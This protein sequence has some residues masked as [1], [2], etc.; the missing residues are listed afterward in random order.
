MVHV[1]KGTPHFSLKKQKQSAPFIITLQYLFCENLLIF[2]KN[3]QFIQCFAA[4][5]FMDDSQLVT[6]VISCEWS[7][8]V[9]INRHLSKRIKWFYSPVVRGICCVCL[10]YG[11][12]KVCFVY[13]NFHFGYFV[14]SICY[15]QFH[16]SQQR[17]PFAMPIL[18]FGVFQWI[19][20]TITLIWHS[21]LTLLCNIINKRIVG[22]SSYAQQNEL[23]DEFDDID[24]II[25]SMDFKVETLY[26]SNALIEIIFCG[27]CLKWFIS[28]IIADFFF[29]LTYFRCSIQGALDTNNMFN[30]FES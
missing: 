27:K 10:E 26:A 9:R 15:K 19:P 12:M 1:K 29:I 20:S 5:W 21:N 4:I 8:L 7:K 22:H 14:L 30:L 6:L 28:P 11:V 3:K 23:N 25:T 24:R 13:W 17:L 2:W 18:I 16:F